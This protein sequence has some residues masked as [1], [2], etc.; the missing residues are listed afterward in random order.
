MASVEAVARENGAAIEA[1]AGRSAWRCF[2]ADDAHGRRCGASSGRLRAAQLTLRA[3]AATPTST[4][5]CGVGR[6]PLGAGAAHAGRRVPSSRC[7][8]PAGHNVQNALAAAACGAGCRRAARRHRAAGLEAFAPGQRALAAAGAALQRRAAS[9]L[10]DDSYNAN[11]DSVRAA[12]DVLAGAAA[13]RAGWCSATW[14]RSATR[15]RS[16]TPRSAPYARERGIEHAV[17]PPAR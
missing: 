2:P 15:A 13:A 10:V 11:P 5:R 6:R 17:V 14:A 9:P 1:L 8:S 3:S 16:S 4:A 12:I 7:A